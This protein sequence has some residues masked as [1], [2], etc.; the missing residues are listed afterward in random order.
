MINCGRSWSFPARGGKPRTSRRTTS[1]TRVLPRA[2]GEA[3]V[4]HDFSRPASGPSPRAGGSHLKLKVHLHVPK[5]TSRTVP[6]GTAIRLSHTRERAN[7][8]IP[9]DDSNR[10]SPDAQPAPLGL[11][12]PEVPTVLADFLSL[13]PVEHVHPSFV[14]QRIP[15]SP[16]LRVLP[17]SA[18]KP[19]RD[20]SGVSQKQLYIT[21]PWPDKTVDCRFRSGLKVGT[22]TIKRKPVQ[23]TDQ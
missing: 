14:H 4:S 21:R 7:D 10:R 22:Q 8:A 13:Q 5:R 12:S 23:V 3:Q 17:T 9:N 11:S 20:R 6:L 1:R 2:R 18:G 19:R 15:V 16:Y